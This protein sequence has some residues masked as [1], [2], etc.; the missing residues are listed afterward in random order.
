[1]TLFLYF[2]VCSFLIRDTHDILKQIKHALIVPPRKY[3][4]LS[5]DFQIDIDWGVI[6][7]WVGMLKQSKHTSI[8]PPR[9]DHYLSNDLQIDIDWGVNQVLGWLVSSQGWREEESILVPEVQTSP[10]VR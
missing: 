5:N 6:K 10:L 7:F 9:K 4:Y 8:V 1:M 3:H 2:L